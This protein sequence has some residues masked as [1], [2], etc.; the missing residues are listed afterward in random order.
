MS[1]Q[2]ITIVLRGCPPGGSGVNSTTNLSAPRSILQLLQSVGTR[3]CAVS[4]IPRADTSLVSIMASRVAGS[5]SVL[6]SRLLTST[7]NH[8]DDS[9]CGTCFTALPRSARITVVGS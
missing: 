7:R 6:A 5:H 3:N 1:R 2:G 8:L 9:S 4:A